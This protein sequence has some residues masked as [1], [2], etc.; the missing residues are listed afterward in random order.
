MEQARMLDELF[1]RL[2]GRIQRV[3][4]LEASKQEI[5]RRI[6]GRRICKA[7]GAIFHVANM[8]P[9]VEGVCDSCGGELYQR[10]DDSEHT[11]LN[12]LD[13]YEQQTASL[14][15]YYRLANL[16]TVIPMGD[17]ASEVAVAVKVLGNPS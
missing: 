12:R 6:T 8:P 13:V 2:G 11:V 9:R 10:A 17:V 15:E 5:L 7:C 14:I 16:L 3:F 1:Q 4:L